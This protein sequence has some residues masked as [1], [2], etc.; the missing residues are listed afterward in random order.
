MPISTSPV[1]TSPETSEGKSAAVQTASTPVNASAAEVSIDTMR[2]CA[3]GLRT[4]LANSDPCAV[5]SAPNTACPVT[6]S[7]PSTF[8]YRFPNCLN[9]NPSAFALVSI[10]TKSLTNGQ[11]CVH[12]AHERN[13]RHS[14]RT[15][16]PP[17]YHAD[18][19]RISKNYLRS[20]ISIYEA[21]VLLRTDRDLEHP[22]RPRTVSSN[23][24]SHP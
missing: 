19:T 14:V 4:N 5:K 18:G 1:S 22:R 13:L 8:R 10:V 23:S 16:S 6:F 3:C 7:S 17:L 20:R 2:A 21:F 15:L 9:S 24:P 11:K 12:R